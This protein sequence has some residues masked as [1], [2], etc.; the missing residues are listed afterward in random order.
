MT[1]ERL[2]PLLSHMKGRVL[3]HEPLS[4]HTSLRTGGPAEAYVYPKNIKELSLLF[5]NITEEKIPYLVLGDGSNVLASDRGF[6]GIVLNLSSLNEIEIIKQN[7]S[8]VDIL[9]GV[10]LRKQT[11]LSWAQERGYSGFE[12]L[13]GIPGQMGGGL[14]MNAGT[15][16]GCFGDVVKEVFILNEN[17]EEVSIS[18][19]T[20]NF[21]Y[22]KQNFCKNN[23]IITRALFRLVYDD[24]EKIEQKVKEMLLD[25]KE[26]QPL[27]YPN[28]GSTFM[29]PVKTS[30]ELTA[31]GLIEHSG[32]K[33]LRIGN[34]MVSTKHANF[35]VNL[36]KATSQ[37]VLSIIENVEKKIKTVHGIHLQRE[38]IVLDY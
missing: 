35:I 17:G 19:N 2:K 27:Q 11:V 30:G 31:G 13:S 16:L 29:N 22:R 12:F 1:A 37:D 26:K 18:V 6:Q 25:R 4:K 15:H 5:K 24:P 32:L 3:W 33:G 23:S 21:F 8:Y 34:A 28:C 9:I 7:T 14:F 36:G 38:V 10:G 20:E